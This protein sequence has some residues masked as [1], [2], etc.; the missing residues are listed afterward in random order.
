MPFICSLRT[1]KS[2]INGGSPDLIQDNNALISLIVFWI[3]TKT[4]AETGYFRNLKY[5]ELI[6]A[7]TTAY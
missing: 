2:N 4:D 7:P 3:E 1:N 5:T 6:N